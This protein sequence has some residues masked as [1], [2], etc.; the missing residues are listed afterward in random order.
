MFNIISKGAMTFKPR[1]TELE[2]NSKPFE[3]KDEF[4]PLRLMYFTPL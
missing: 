1:R 4:S 3:S 2:Y